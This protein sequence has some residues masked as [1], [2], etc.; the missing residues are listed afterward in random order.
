MNFQIPSN[1]LDVKIHLPSRHE[2]QLL[3][4]AAAGAGAGRG[5]GGALSKHLET[6]SG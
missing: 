2:S 4:K 1:T 5:C 3:R 6:L